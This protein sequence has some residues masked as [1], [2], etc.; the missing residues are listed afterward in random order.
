M[1]Y[2]I[3]IVLIILIGYFVTNNTSQIKQNLSFLYFACEKGICYEHVN[4]CYSPNGYQYING[5][6]DDK[7]IERKTLKCILEPTDKYKLM[8]LENIFVPSMMDGTFCDIVYSTYYDYN[9]LTVLKNR[10][11]N[12]NMPLCKCIRIRKY[13]FNPKIYLEI[14]YSGGT[15][16]RATIDKYYNLLES[17][18]LEEENKAIIVNILNKIKNNKINPIFNNAYK[19]LSF[20]Y[21]HDPS[22]RITIDTNIEFFKNQLYKIMDTDILEFKIPNSV[23][24]GEAEQFLKEINMFADTKLQFSKFSKFEYYYYNVISNQ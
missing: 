23:S 4:K 16:I 19:R 15:K 22:M 8:K 3:L 2:I 21:K 14:K 13:H 17:E 5:S 1:K 24:I 11:Y 12:L 20:I 6:S 7:K 10:I 9:D 18:T